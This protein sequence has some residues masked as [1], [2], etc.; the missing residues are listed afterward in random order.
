MVNNEAH[1]VVFGKQAWTGYLAV[2]ILNSWAAC[3]PQRSEKSLAFW[4]S[5]PKKRNAENDGFN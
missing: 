4:T 5:G 1:F 3:Y 2:Q